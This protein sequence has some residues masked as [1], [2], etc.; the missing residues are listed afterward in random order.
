MSRRPD[1]PIVASVREAREQ[2]AKECGYHLRR[3]LKALKDA[4]G[5]SGRPGGSPRRQGTESGADRGR[6][7]GEAIQAEMA[8][9]RLREMS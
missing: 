3:L 9:I 1:N 6:S 2:L 8:S 7:A 4:E 5:A